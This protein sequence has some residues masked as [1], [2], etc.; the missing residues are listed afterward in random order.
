MLLYG[1]NHKLRG[2]HIIFAKAFIAVVKIVLLC[3]NY[4]VKGQLY[5]QKQDL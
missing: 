2:V 5:E 1:K 3:Y 4:F